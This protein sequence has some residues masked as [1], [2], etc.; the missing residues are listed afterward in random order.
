MLPVLSDGSN[1]TAQQDVRL[2]GRLIPK[3]TMIWLFFNGMFNSSRNWDSP[4]SY[5]P[6]PDP[7]F[8]WS[9]VWGEAAGSCISGGVNGVHA[10]MFCG[11]VYVAALCGNDTG[12]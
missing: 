5:R 8:G 2:G 1:R 10:S 11:K 9:M 3:G 7:G 4:A 6:V 12:R